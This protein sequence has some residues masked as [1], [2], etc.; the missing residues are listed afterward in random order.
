[1]DRNRFYSII[2]SMLIAGLVAYMINIITKC[3][4]VIINKENFRD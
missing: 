4:D 2:I 3:P 1:M